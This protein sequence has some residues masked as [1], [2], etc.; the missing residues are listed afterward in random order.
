MKMQI[1]EECYAGDVGPRFRFWSF[2]DVQEALK[3]AMSLWGRSPRVGHVAVQAA[4]PQFR[5]HTM[6][7][8]YDDRGGSLE[9]SDLRP[10]PLS[11]SEVEERDRVSNWLTFIDGDLN[12]RIVGLAVGQLARGFARPSWSRIAKQLNQETHVKY[13]HDALRMRYARAIRS[14]CLALEKGKG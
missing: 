8:D 14:I 7:G 12:R 1:G 2:D 13:G 9:A 3:A 11:V 4:W 5:R 10:L 6:W